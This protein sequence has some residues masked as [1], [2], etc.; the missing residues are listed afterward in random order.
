M[1]RKNKN[2]LLFVLWL[3]SSGAYGAA[4][5]GVGGGIKHTDGPALHASASIYK[6]V[7]LHY[8][9]WRDMGRDRAAGIGYRFQNGSPISVVVGYAHIG[10]VTE[11]L[12]RH[13]DAYIELR[14]QFTDSFACQ[15]SHYS[16]IGD[17]AGENIALCGILFFR[18]AP[19][20]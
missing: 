11:N 2:K 9:H 8:S 19:E 1:L 13:N 18:R 5:V 4:F 17:D 6:A 20:E 16:T 3:W 12:L 10:R 15:I 14:W 7:E